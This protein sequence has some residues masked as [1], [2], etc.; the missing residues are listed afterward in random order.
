MLF[1]I[2][3]VPLRKEKNNRML[4]VGQS[5][6]LYINR[7][8]P[9]GAYLIC[10]LEDREE[11]EFEEVLLP[12][13]YITDDMEPD[14]RVEVFVHYDSEDRIVATTDMPLIKVG[15]VAQL[16]VV[17]RNDYGVFL[18]WGLPKDLFLPFGNQTFHP[19]VGDWCVV[20]AYIDDRTGR[21]VATLKMNKFVSNSDLSDIQVG[22]EVSIVLAEQNDYG[23][24]CV[25]D[26]KHWGMVYSNQIFK[27]V[28]I[29]DMMKGYIANITE[30][31]RVDILLQ[32]MGRKQVEE[33]SSVLLKLLDK[34]DGV[35]HLGDKSSPDKI[36]EKTQMSKKMFKRG[37][38][39]L[40]KEGRIKIEDEK[41][42]LI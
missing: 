15:E 35:L 28:Y 2:N 29:G 8:T 20:Y 19:R 37:V 38:G 5:Q 14:T 11:E 6:P 1:L 10:N 30:D 18:D 3:L 42:E 40:L 34:G 31:N 21:I 26:N 22:D 32:P 13:R 27:E 7:F 33:S 16:Q 36:Y 25:I 9:Q 4:I 12:N 17:D 24:R 39:V 23:F 41:I